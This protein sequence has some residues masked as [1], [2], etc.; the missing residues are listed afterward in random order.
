M[1]CL[2]ALA[3]E[4]GCA[5]WGLDF[6]AAPDGEWLVTGASPL[7]ELTQGDEESADA[8][9]EAPGFCFVEPQAKLRWHC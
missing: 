3:H 9:A 6:T 8:L 5:L 7:P 2:F 4:A 1:N